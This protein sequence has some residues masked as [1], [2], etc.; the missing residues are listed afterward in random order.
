MV[1]ALELLKS[2]EVKGNFVVCIFL[3]QFLLIGI[4]RQTLDTESLVLQLKG[5][6]PDTTADIQYRMDVAGNKLHHLFD[7]SFLSHLQ[8]F[9]G[10]F[11][12][13]VPV[14]KVKV[15]GFDER[16]QIEQ[17]DVDLNIFFSQCLPRFGLPAR[18]SDIGWLRKDLFA[19]ERHELIYLH[20]RAGRFEVGNRNCI[21]TAG[22]PHDNIQSNR[23][24]SCPNS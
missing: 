13:L 15:F 6:A 23:I 8:I 17:S 11:I 10:Q 4:R 20:F 2:R 5:I 21:N 3:E 1:A 12:S 24:K 14:A 7:E 9:Q 16:Q 22:E 19:K 18:S